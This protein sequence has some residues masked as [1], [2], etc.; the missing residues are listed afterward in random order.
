M[1]NNDKDVTRLQQIG[2]LVTIPFVLVV[3]PMVGWFI[4]K[5]IDRKWGTKP[6][7]MY[8]LIILGIVAAIRECYRI[9]KRFANEK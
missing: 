4:G 1:K 8:G 5:W 7:F 2:A 3:P 9:I 6:Y